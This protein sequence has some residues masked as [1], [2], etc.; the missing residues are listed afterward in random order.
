VTSKPPTTIDA[1]I[2]SQPPKLRAILRRIRSTIRKAAPNAVEK[3]SYRMPAFFQNGVLIYYAAFKNHIGVYPP[4]HGD[5][6]LM[7]AIAK[8]QGPKGNL[9]FPL[10]QPMPYELVSRIVKAR[11]RENGHGRAQ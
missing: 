3:I 11:L 7:K 8:Y 10:D 5:A 9:R 4:V 1:Y 2:A 6:K